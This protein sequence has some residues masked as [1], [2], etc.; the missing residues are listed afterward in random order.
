MSRYEYFRKAD[1]GEHAVWIPLNDVIVTPDMVDPSSSSNPFNYLWQS[2]CRREYDIT[3]SAS[4]V[5]YTING[6]DV[7]KLV[8]FVFN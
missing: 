2:P 3:S 5:V 7:D 6:L 4:N 8:E 1:G